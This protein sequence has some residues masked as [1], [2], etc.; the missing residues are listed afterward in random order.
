MCEINV[1]FYFFLFLYLMLFLFYFL[2]PLSFNLG[3]S[4]LLALYMG[5]AS[6]WCAFS[7]FLF[8][9]SIGFISHVGSRQVS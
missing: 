4:P 3:I 8:F 5:Y 7:L 1:D 9:T 6:V 2:P